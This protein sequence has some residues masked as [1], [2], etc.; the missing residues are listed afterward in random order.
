M[1][2]PEF[3]SRYE[4][5][6]VDAN[7]GASRTDAPGGMGSTAN[8]YLGECVNVARQFLAQCCGW[9]DES[10]G[11]GGDYGRLGEACEAKRGAI[12]FLT[13][14]AAQNQWGHVGVC[15]GDWHGDGEVCVFEQNAPTTAHPAGVH[16]VKDVWYGRSFQYRDVGYTEKDRQTESEEDM[17]A[18]TSVAT[19]K[20]PSTGTR[21]AG[22]YL[23]YGDG[24]YRK[25]GG[26]DA[27]TDT[28]FPP[29][30]LLPNDWPTLVRQ[31]GLKEK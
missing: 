25:V 22:R 10:H 7:G 21:D 6:Y 31:C 2:L 9:P 19:W 28:A 26:D 11:N 24:T 17:A 12:A 14:S 5:L 30:T 18:L 15:L 23:I 16:R 13:P 27:I 1:N 29:K 4:G 3:V 20:D 8:A